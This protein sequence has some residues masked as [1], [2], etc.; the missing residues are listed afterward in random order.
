MIKM[1]V[2]AFI[3]YLGYRVFRNLSQVWRLMKTPPPPS[4]RSPVEAKFEVEDGK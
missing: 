3:A 4:G 1:A 2:W